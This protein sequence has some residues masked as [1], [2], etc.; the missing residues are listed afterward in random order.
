MV[1]E[2]Y[3]KILEFSIF[4][5]GKKAFIN[6]YANLTSIHLSCLL[7]MKVETKYTNAFANEKNLEEREL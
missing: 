2:F 6:I 7:F 4:E 3:L 5:V 1:L